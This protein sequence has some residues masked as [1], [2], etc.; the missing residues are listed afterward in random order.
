MFSDQRTKPLQIICPRGCREELLEICRLGYEF[1]IEMLPFKV[2]FVE[3]EPEGELFLADMR[4][5]FA[6]TLHPRKNLAVRVDNPNGQSLAYSGDGDITRSAR[7]LYWEVG[8]LV[9][10][11]YSFEPLEEI[12]TQIDDT[13][14]LAKEQRVKKL[15]LTHLK[16]KDRNSKQFKDLVEQIHEKVEILA[17]LPG[18]E[19]DIYTHFANHST[20]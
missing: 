7:E 9:H 15:F 13:I 8:C 1:L 2:N 19:F 20:Q 18:Q 5:R 3:V 12:H 16:R 11:A 6:R 17:P 10:D 4:W 14:V